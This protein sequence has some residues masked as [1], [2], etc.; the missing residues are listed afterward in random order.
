LINYGIKFEV[1]DILTYHFNLKANPPLFARNQFAEQ[2][3]MRRR[4]HFTGDF[5][6]GVIRE[7][8]RTSLFWP[9]DR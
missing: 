1:V 9:L 8:G 6:Q 4:S 2:G 5:M 7:V 3:M